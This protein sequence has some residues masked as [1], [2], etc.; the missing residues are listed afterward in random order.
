MKKHEIYYTIDRFGRIKKDNYTT[1]INNH[2]WFTPVF[3]IILMILTA[4]VEGNL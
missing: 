3:I 4:W 1:F 2:A